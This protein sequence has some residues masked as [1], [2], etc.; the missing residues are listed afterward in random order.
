MKT[1]HKIN[2]IIIAAIVMIVAVINL[3][4]VSQDW[5]NYPNPTTAK[6]VIL[7]TYQALDYPIDGKTCYYY[8]VKAD[9]KYTR[10][11]WPNVDMEILHSDTLL[12]LHNCGS[13]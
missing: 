8:Q 3:V 13:D 7:G 4:G 5:R 2:L 9:V 10:A 11:T 12:L 1:K 6:N